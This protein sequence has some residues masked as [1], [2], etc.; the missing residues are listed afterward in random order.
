MYIYIYIYMCV[1]SLDLT[2]VALSIQPEIKQ[3]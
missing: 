2:Q 1:I 3:S